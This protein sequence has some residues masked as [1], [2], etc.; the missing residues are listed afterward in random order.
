M[1]I[2]ITSKKAKKIEI[3]FLIILTL[4][5]II[6]CIKPIQ[7]GTGEIGIKAKPLEI[8]DRQFYINDK[9]P[10]SQ[11]IFIEGK[12]GP[13]YPAILK[14]I[15]FVSIKV[16][17]QS[18]NSYLWN[19][20]AIL[21]SSLLTFLTI[22]F[23][24]ASGK[25]LQGESTGIIAMIFFTFCPYTYFYALSGGITIYTLFGTTLSTYLIL[26]I[27]HYKRLSKQKK[28]SALSKITLSLVLIYMSLLR[29]S[30]IIF[31]LIVAMIMIFF[32]I[33]NILRNQINR[34]LTA[35]IILIFTLTSILSFY[36]LWVSRIYSLSA[37]NAFSIEGGTFM[38]IDRNLIRDKIELFLQSPNKVKNIEGITYKILWKTNDFFTGIID[39]RDTHNPLETPLLSFLVRISVGTLFLAPLTYLSIIGTFFLRKVILNSGL[40]ISL[41]ACMFSFSPSLIGVAMSRYYYMF[42][43]P[44]ILISS[45]TI[46]KIS[47]KNILHNR[48]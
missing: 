14:G 16:F 27:N 43:T 30:S 29:P 11:N 42:I 48:Q 25:A 36:Q 12:G 6:S 1:S 45:M 40:W 8:I 23:A 5:I 13:L 17:N 33:K 19:S 38:G 7:A 3:V 41:I 18:T 10:L 20:I 31:S 46:S 32:E 28:N 47:N 35:F 37:L 21:F 39:L 34:K 4:S 2:E 9:D 44:C 15:S 24:Y 22:R 26:K